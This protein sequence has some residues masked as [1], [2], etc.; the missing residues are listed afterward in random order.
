MQKREGFYCK[1]CNA[2]QGEHGSV[3]TSCHK[4]G[5]EVYYVEGEEDTDYLINHNED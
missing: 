3:E 4:C 1:Q 2:Y 5:G